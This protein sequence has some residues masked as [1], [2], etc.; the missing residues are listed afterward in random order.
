MQTVAFNF[1]RF[2]L[3]FRALDLTCFAIPS[4][5]LQYMGEN[6]NIN[7]LQYN[8]FFQRNRYYFLSTS[9]Q[10][11]YGILGRTCT[12]ITLSMTYKNIVTFILESASK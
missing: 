10:Q 6:E 9:R 11:W 12:T 5:K 2:W 8:Y 7:A 1:V 4:P 3:G